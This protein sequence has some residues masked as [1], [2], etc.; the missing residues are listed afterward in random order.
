[1]KRLK[2]QI[3]YVALL[4]VCL[5]SGC[6]DFLDSYNPSAVTD[7]FYN[8]KEGQQKLPV[9]AMSLIQASCNITEQI[10][11]WLSP[12]NLPNV[13]STDTIR[14]STLPLLSW[15][16]TGKCFI[17]LCRKAISC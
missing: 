1:M 8:T 11:I 4:A 9:T 17:R 7:D 2:E 16:I 5:L 15:A 6:S 12:K 14:R 3:K 13:C 10:S